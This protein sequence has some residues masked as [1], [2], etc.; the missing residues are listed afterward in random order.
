[1]VVLL[2]AMETELTAEFMMKISE[3]KKKKELK[4]LNVKFL[5]V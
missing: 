4:K 1:M 3:K 2:L 5:R